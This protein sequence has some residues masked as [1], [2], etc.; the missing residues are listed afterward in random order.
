[1]HDRI[2][3]WREVTFD[4]I[5]RV[6]R[7]PG[8]CYG[9]QVELQISNQHV[10]L[11]YL[12]DSLTL[13]ELGEIRLLLQFWS[14]TGST[15]DISNNTMKPVTGRPFACQTGQVCRKLA[16]Q[17]VKVVVNKTIHFGSLSG[18]TLN[19]ESIFAPLNRE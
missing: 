11:G 16:E 14:R 3:W 6:G 15:P 10:E 2:T 8:L 19:E 4:G 17:S 1:V 7:Y 18:L 5:W 13:V 12:G 9:Q